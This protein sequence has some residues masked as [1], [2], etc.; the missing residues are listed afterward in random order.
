MSR[1]GMELTAEPEADAREGSSREPVSYRAAGSVKP[2]KPTRADWR[3]VAN[4]LCIPLTA[5]AAL[6]VHYLL[7]DRG[8]V[9]RT[10]VYAGMLITIAAM[11]VLAIFLRM[12]SP[13]ARAWLSARSPLFA[14]G[15]VLL[16]TW[17]LIT[18]KL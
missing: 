6:A 8:P 9:V 14:G 12:A 3:A 2:S 11:G 18:A 5:G 7:P 17:D 15:L 1:Q 13:A 4:A 10:S 16:C